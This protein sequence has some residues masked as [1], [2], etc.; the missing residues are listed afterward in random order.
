MRY[1]D[2]CCF[3]NE[4]DLL[5]LRCEELKELNPIHVIVEASTTHTG[6]PKP[7]Y[8]EE[9]KHLFSEYNIR[10]IKT[11]DLP[12]NGNAW[13]AENKQRDLSLFGLY[14]CEDEDIVGI[15][16]LDEIP[17]AEM[18]KKYKPEMGV[19]GVKMDKFSYFLNCVEGYQQWEMGKLL[20]Y[21]MLKKTT[22]NKVRN[23]GHE[24][25]MC[26]A[27]WHFSFLGGVEKMKEKLFAYAHTET[28]TSNLLNRLERKFE[29][30]QSLWGDDYWRFVDIDDKFP[31]YLREH[32]DEFSH[33]IRK[34]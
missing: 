10:H 23:G 32:Q 12:N 28:V 18:V 5:K 17:K 3:F 6:I 25:I 19:T 26:E 14:D 2:T 24:T 21:G 4:I 30:G 16:D 20:T 22:P 27:G 15:F 11:D 9:N 8:F 34:V 1:Y 29:S 31:K 13:D 7:Y 33:L